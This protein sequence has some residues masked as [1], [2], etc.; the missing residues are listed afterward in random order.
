MQ[1]L[2]ALI[3]SAMAFLAARWMSSPENINV[4]LILLAIVLALSTFFTL[5]AIKPFDLPIMR[6]PEKPLTQVVHETP[7]PNRPSNGFFSL[8]FA[9][10]LIYMGMLK[11]PIFW[12]LLFRRGIASF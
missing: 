11:P 2:M 9:I 5:W 12:D 3:G 6:A 1:V 4:I 8:V 10:F 7:R